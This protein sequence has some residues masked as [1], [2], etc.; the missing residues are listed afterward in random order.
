MS[1]S[2][3]FEQLEP[4]GIICPFC[5][6]VHPWEG[7]NWHHYCLSRASSRGSCQMRYNNDKQELYYCTG[8]TC[9]RANQEMNG[10]ISIKEIE[11]QKD[12]PKITF[13]IP[14]KSRGMVNHKRCAECDFVEKCTFA[15][16]GEEGDGINMIVPFGLVFDR[17]EYF[18]IVKENDMSF[19]SEILRQFWKHAPEENFGII[20]EWTEKHKSTLQWAMPVVSIYTAYRILKSPTFKSRLGKL[21]KECEE[22]L[23]F[24][25]EPLNDQTALREIMIFGLSA[26]GAYAAINGIGSIFKD[27]DKRTFENL[28]KEMDNLEK[29]HKGF[30]WI[31]PKTEALMPVAISVI[32]F[33]MMTQK[34]EAI[35]GAMEKGESI[36]E[37]LSCGAVMFFDFFKLFVKDKMKFDLN[38]K[39]EVKKLKKFAVLAAIAGGGI[40]LYGTKN[41]NEKE[42]N[43]PEKFIKQLLQ[44][45]QKLMPTVF[46]G[47]TAYLV[48]KNFVPKEYVEVVQTEAEEPERTEII[49]KAE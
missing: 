34:P 10:A 19:T 14:F 9:Q 6:E 8:I 13:C 41:G 11:V 18:K 20:K 35:K 47:T 1:S 42:H 24:T 28:E 5:G 7:W 29:V 36:K 33:Y 46:A 15:R 31:T 26:A 21:G 44:A 23:G 39:E 3:L 43:V 25:L 12:E 17:E 45:M 40:I 49:E 32:V 27:K 37:D 16:L 38:N 22:K 2:E 48:A 4:N 30:S